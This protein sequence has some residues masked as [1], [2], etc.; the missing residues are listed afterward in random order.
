MTSVGWRCATAMSSAARTNSVRRW[1]SIAQPATRR[2][3][4]SSTTA[5]KRKPAQVGT[6]VMS[7]T[8]SRL[9]PGAVNS[10][11]TRSGAHR[12]TS[13]RTVVL[14]D[15]RRLTPCSPALHISRATRLRPIWIP[16]SLSSACT[17]GTPYV[18][19][20]SRCTAWISALELH[21]RPRTERERPLA[22]RVVSARGDTQDAAH[23]GDRMDGLVCRHELESLDGIVLVS[24][25]NQAAAF[26]R[27]ARSSR[28]WRTS[29][30]SR[31][32]SSRSSAV[33]PSVRSP[34]SRAVCFTQFRIA[35]AEG[36]NWRPSSSGVRP[37]R[38]NSM[39]R[40]RNSGAYGRWLFGIVDAPF[41]PNHGVSTKPEAV[42]RGHPAAGSVLPGVRSPCGADLHEVSQRAARRREILLR[43]RGGRRV[44]GNS[45]TA[46]R[47]ARV[48]HA[49]APRRE[50]PHV[51]ERARR[52]A[53]AG[54]RP[55]RRPQGLDGAARR[56]RSRGGAEDS[57][58]R[59]RT[60][61]GGRAPL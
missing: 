54:D 25:A 30:R 43:V 38:T 31:R 5:R 1:V 58:P 12:A 40:R 27:I 23:G 22:P 9:G 41:R 53:Q 7:A 48:L 55:L 46:I 47:I 45:R 18:P 39:R 8:H 61:D 26:D 13:F 37:F 11:S 49:E 24:R 15:L 14:T 28:S 29:R 3:Q 57:R 51:Q 50:N 56:P 6:Y 35:C 34:A 20:D 32:N 2:L 33:S 19:R 4:A 21:I 52:R 36:S 42:S 17:R 10:R 16:R 59:P 44:A 60:H